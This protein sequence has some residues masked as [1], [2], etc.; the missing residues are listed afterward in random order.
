M[1]VC[2]CFGVCV[3]DCEISIKFF[4]IYH[5]INCPFPQLWHIVRR[6]K[7][8][9]VTDEPTLDEFQIA[10]REIGVKITMLL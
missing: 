4:S 2:V 5:N 9:I 6:M 7:L 8:N 3:I 1:C 10:H